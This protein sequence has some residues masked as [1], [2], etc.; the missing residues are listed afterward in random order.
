MG[1]TI[2]LLH[3]KNQMSVSTRKAVL[4]LQLCSVDAFIRVGVN[5]K[6]ILRKVV[7]ILEEAPAVECFTMDFEI[8]STKT[9]R[10]IWSCQNVQ[11]AQVH[12]QSNL[13]IV[14]ASIPPWSRH[15]A[16][17]SETTGAGDRRVHN[18]SRTYSHNYVN[19][20]WLA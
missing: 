12:A 8:G 4:L 9:H 1:R 5:M 18:Q 2:F 10:R 14:S 16:G 3:K 11:K 6:Q 15:L 20:K 19:D 17:L 13:Q 7:D